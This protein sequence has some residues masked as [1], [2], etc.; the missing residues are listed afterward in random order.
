MESYRAKPTDNNLTLH[1]D[2]PQLTTKDEFEQV[3]HDCRELFVNKLHDYGAA[4]RVMRPETMTDQIFIK[5]ARIRSLQMK[6]QAMVDEGIIPE[7]IGIV[8][9]SIVALIQ[10]EKGT[11]NDKD[12]T[13]EEALQL[14]DKHAQDSLKLMLRKN[15][16]YNEAWRSM[17]VSSYADLIFMKLYRTK[18]IE[19]LEG[20]TL[21]SEG[22]AANYMDIMNYAVFGL[23]KLTIE[24]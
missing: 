1:T 20:Q 7:F 13:D 2:M 21:V 9:Y 19:E 4:W 23:I 5:A 22:V 12:I 14:Y 10:L 16:D 24:N 18:Q 6:K 17:R 3:M 15:H 8:N 11:A